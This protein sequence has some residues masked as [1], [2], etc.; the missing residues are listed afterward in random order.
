MLGSVFALRATPDTRDGAMSASSCAYPHADRC[1]AQ[2]GAPCLNARP[3]RP[4]PVGTS[5]YLIL[6]VRSSRCSSHPAFYLGRIKCRYA[7]SLS[8]VAGKLWRTRSGRATPHQSSR[9]DVL[10]LSCR[11]GRC[12][13][14]L[15]AFRQGRLCRSLLASS[16]ERKVF[17]ATPRQWFILKAYLYA[18]LFPARTGH[19][20][21]MRVVSEPV[22]SF[23]RRLKNKASYPV[24][25]I[26]LLART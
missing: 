22:R 16:P 25:A 13:Q 12:R 23:S 19:S 20:A 10:F 3:A 7:K 1:D 21:E 14:A 8:A 5:A 18:S 11:G 6:C 24:L 4:N 9:P 17:R 2:A 15:G 26:F